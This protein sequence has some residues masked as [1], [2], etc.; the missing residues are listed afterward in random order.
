M[1]NKSEIAKLFKVVFAKMN[2]IVLYVAAIKRSITTRARVETG[3]ASLTWI[4]ARV[5]VKRKDRQYL[6]LTISRTNAL[7]KVHTINHRV[8]SFCANTFRVTKDLMIVV[9]SFVVLCI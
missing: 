7:R 6:T 9:N 3:S 5:H 8:L 1:A 4:V 2:R